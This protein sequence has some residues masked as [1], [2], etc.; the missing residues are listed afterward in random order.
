MI[1][2]VKHP[3]LDSGFALIHQHTLGDRVC[4]IVQAIRRQLLHLQIFDFQID[5]LTSLV[6][7]VSIPLAV[8]LSGFAEMG[9]QGSLAASSGRLADRK[10][11]V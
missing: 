2:A 7:Q 6:G 4:E 10:S 11:V 8:E 3:V 1:L 5:D 9:I